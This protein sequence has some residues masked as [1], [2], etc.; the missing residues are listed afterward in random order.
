MGKAKILIIDDDELI[1]WSLAKVLEKEGYQVAMLHQ[2]KDVFDSVCTSAPD[3]ILLDLML[4]DIPGLSILKSLKEK[5]CQVPV[6][7]ITAMTDVDTAVEA[8]KLGAQDYLSKP[9][10]MEEVVIAVKK[11]LEVDYL[12]REMN[13]R[14]SKESNRYHFENIIAVDPAMKKIVQLARQLSKS[15]ATTIL[16]QGESGTGKDL[17]A[18]TIHYQSRRWIHPIVEINCTAVPE[19]L[20]ESEL[21]GHERGAF[22]DAKQMKRGLFEIAQGGTILLQEVGDMSQAMQAK[23]LKVLEDRRIRRIGGVKDIEIDVCVIA[24][25][26]RNLQKEVEDDRFRL[27]LFYRFNTIT[28]TIPPLRRRKQDILPLTEYYIKQFNRQFRRNVQTIS[29]EARDLLLQYPWPGNVRQLKNVIERIMILEDITELQP[30]HL[31]EEIQKPELYKLDCS[32]L[33]QLPERGIA[34]DEVEKQLILQALQ[35]TNGNQVQAAK[36]LHI[37]RD[38][39]RRKMQK[40]GL[41]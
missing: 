38:A 20:L 29:K 12:K 25:T 4:P 40:H 3:L 14:R 7:V 8:M 28:L 15:E 21:F 27:D 5:Q 23:L 26:N 33:F 17:L 41:L 32:K 37:S 13:Y 18:R 30:E 36:L 34:L 10:N 19:T 16:I 11:A 1:C 22:T 2:G 24:T 31:P 35:M 6:L 39:F 9:F